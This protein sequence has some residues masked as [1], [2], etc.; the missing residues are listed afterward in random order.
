MQIDKNAALEA[1]AAALT[2]RF[3][4]EGDIS[5]AVSAAIDADLS[6][7]ESLGDREYDEE[8]SYQNTVKALKGKVSDPEGFAEDF[9]E[10]WESYLNLIGAIEWDG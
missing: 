4:H 5:A 2:Q 7:I 3:G 10:A 8:K 1:V 9:A 6:Y